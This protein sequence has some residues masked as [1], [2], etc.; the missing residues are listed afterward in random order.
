MAASRGFDVR[1][2]GSTARGEDGEKSDLDLLVSLG[3]EERFFEAFG[4]IADMRKVVREAKIDA[5]LDIMARPEVRK[6]ALEEG[7]PL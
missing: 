5:V 1:V 3:D 6:A 4:L 2:F 7:I